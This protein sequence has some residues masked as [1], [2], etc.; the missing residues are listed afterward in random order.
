MNKTKMFIGSSLMTAML[1][2]TVSNSGGVSGGIAG[3]SVSST[4]T[5]SVTY[6]SNGMTIQREYSVY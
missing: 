6:V 5:T 4:S 1:S 3:F 2:T